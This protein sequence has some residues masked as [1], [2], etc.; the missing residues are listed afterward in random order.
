MAFASMS[1][2]KRIFYDASYVVLLY[3]ISALKAFYTFTHSHMNAFFYAQCLLANIH[4]PINTSESN[5]GCSN[6]LGDT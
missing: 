6:L 1:A 2:C 3:S 4:S 5:S